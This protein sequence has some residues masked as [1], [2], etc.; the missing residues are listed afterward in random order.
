VQDGETNSRLFVDSIPG[1]V[2]LMTPAGDLE[3]VNRAV[4]AYFSKTLEQL[5]HWA[6]DDTVHPADRARVFEVFKR[7]IASGEPYK[8]EA[9]FRRFD[10]V[11]RWFQCRGLPHRDATGGIVRWYAT[12]IDID[13]RKRAEEALRRSR[14][15]RL[16]ELERVRRRIATDLHDDIGSSL[17]QI[18]ILSEVVQQRINHQDSRVTEQLSMIAGASRELVDAMSD[19]VWAIN[20]QKD[21]LHDLTQRMRRFAA[22]SFTAR[23]IKFQLRLPPAEEDVKLGANLRREVFLIFKEGVNNMVRHSGCTQAD[24]EL[25]FVDGRLRLRLSDNGRGFDATRENDGHGLVSMRDRAK[26][27]G[28]QFELHSQVGY[29]TVIELAVPFDQ[30]QSIE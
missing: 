17:T 5:K 20:P 10:G 18:S 4:T 30:Q 11:Y 23:N 9:R 27:I 29:G 28:G 7:A 16:V 2:L 12:G 19:I 14:E 26:S 3:V 21:H 8:F 6:T 13:Q 15:E 22:D 25:S 1:I 24:I